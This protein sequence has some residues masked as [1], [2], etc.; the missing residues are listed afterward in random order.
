[1]TEF[2]DEDTE[3][4]YAQHK[5]AADNLASSETEISGSRESFS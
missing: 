1:M 2:L 3:A 5:K 4:I